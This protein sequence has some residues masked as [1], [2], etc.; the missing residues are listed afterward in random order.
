VEW[1]FVIA[2][3]VLLG[4]KVFLARGQYRRTRAQNRR[5]PDADDTPDHLPGH[6]G[7]SAGG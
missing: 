3:L 2:V 4:A 1:V 7:G 6:G 5:H